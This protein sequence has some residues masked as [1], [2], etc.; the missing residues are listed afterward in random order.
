MLLVYQDTSAVKMDNQKTKD[1]Y[2]NVY[3]LRLLLYR[4]RKQ[5]GGC[6]Y[7]RREIQERLWE[8][9]SY[10]WLKKNVSGDAEYALHDYESC[11]CDKRVIGKQKKAAANKKRKEYYETEEGKQTKNKYREIAKQKNNLIKELKRIKMG[12][13]SQAELCKETIAKLSNMI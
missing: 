3:E 12:R 10:E 8:N 7:T 9:L 5:I 11:T 2:S 13:R 6:G 4:N 1:I